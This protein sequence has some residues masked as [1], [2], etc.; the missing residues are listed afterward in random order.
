MMEKT[1][2]L[3]SSGLDSPVAAYLLIKSGIEPVFLFFDANQYNSKKTRET[4]I[5]LGRFLAGIA[6]KELTM[7]VANHGETIDA[8]KRAARG[9]DVKYTCIFCKR[10]YYMIAKKLANKVNASAISSG[11]IIGEQA[12]QTMDNLAVIQEAI[13]TYLILR[14]LLCKDK[15]EVIDIAR[16]IGTY[17]ISTEAARE[18]CLAVPKYPSTHA[19]LEKYKQI[20][21][22]IDLDAI[23][24]RVLATAK[25]YQ[26]TPNEGD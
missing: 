7:F 3:L 11:E 13:G 9:N 25:E 19:Q 6:G 10:V 16:K 20:E 12:S 2:H 4:A 14:P 22:L 18:K 17:Q 21:G 24:E 15:Q 26:L 8:F 23:I 5:K 1:V